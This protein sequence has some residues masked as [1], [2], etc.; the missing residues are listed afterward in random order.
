MPDGSLCH[1]LSAFTQFHVFSLPSAAFQDPPKVSQRRTQAC[2]AGKHKH[3][4]IVWSLPYFGQPWH[5]KALDTWAA[6]EQSPWPR[7]ANISCHGLS[8]SC[9]RNEIFWFDLSSANQAPSFMMLLGMRKPDLLGGCSFSAQSLEQSR[10]LLWT[11]QPFLQELFPSSSL[12]QTTIFQA[13]GLQGMGGSLATLG[14]IATTPNIKEVQD[15]RC[16]H[17]G[18]LQGKTWPEATI[19]TESEPRYSLPLLMARN[20][21]AAEQWQ[22]QCRKHLQIQHIIGLTICTCWSQWQPAQLQTLMSLLHWN[23]RCQNTFSVFQP[24]L[25]PCLT[26]KISRNTR[27]MQHDILVALHIYGIYGIWSFHPSPNIT[28]NAARHVLRI[29][30]KRCHQCPDAEFWLTQWLRGGAPKIFDVF[31]KKETGNFRYILQCMI[32]GP[33]ITIVTIKIAVLKSTPKLKSNHSLQSYVLT[34]HKK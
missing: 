25:N 15:V 29:F 20:W 4:F 22:N 6:K 26:P 23:A 3:G 31:Q 24:G 1:V 32:I 11:G 27:D 30:A 7:S 19:K 2:I 18:R 33:K 28:Q 16:I 10:N 12:V 17:S 13:K 14:V 21:P 8:W 34:T 9:H 5:Q